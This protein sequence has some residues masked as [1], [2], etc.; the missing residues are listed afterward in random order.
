MRWI[1][2]LVVLIHGSFVPTVGAFL[3]QTPISTRLNTGGIGGGEL[4]VLGD[5]GQIQQFPLEHTDVQVEIVGNVARVELIQ[6]FTNPY[7]KK[8]EAVYVFPL[9][10]RAAVDDMEIQVGERTIKAIIK[11]SLRQQCVT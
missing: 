8:I 5:V 4:R 1:P 10:N 7:D 11:V 9:P 6:K 3:G 2:I